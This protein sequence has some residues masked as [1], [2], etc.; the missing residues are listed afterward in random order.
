MAPDP[1]L[2]AALAD[3]RA[4][5]TFWST[6]APTVGGCGDQA[7]GLR[8][9]G[10]ELGIFSPLKSAV[11]GVSDLVRDRCSEGE[12]AMDDIADKVANAA[13]LIEE[14]DRW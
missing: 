4:D 13:K 2:T 6:T 8:F 10:A 12:T 5:A 7:A 14:A 11:N 1:A 3:I 9:D